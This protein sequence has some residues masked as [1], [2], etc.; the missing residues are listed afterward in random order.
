MTEL[1]VDEAGVVAF[2]QE[3][4]RI[5]SVNDPGALATALQSAVRSDMAEAFASTY[6]VSAFLCLATFVVALFLP[7]RHEESHLLDEEDEEPTPVAS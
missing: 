7:R 3:L 4:V 1:T 6:W 2:T 5:R